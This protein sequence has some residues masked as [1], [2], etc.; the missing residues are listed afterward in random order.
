MLW[1]RDF[2]L[3]QPKQAETGPTAPKNAIRPARGVLAVGG[4]ISKPVQCEFESHRGHRF[5]GSVCADRGDF[6]GEQACGRASRGHILATL[7]ATESRSE[8]NKLA[9]TSSAIAA[10]ACPSI[11]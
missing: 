5:C 10:L 3:I 8:S 1:C 4:T 11:R 2:T 6:C 9:Y 7:S